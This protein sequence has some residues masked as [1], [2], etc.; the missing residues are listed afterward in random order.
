LPAAKVSAEKCVH[1]LGQTDARTTTKGEGGDGSPRTRRRGE[2]MLAELI[3]ATAM[4]AVG[5]D[6]GR[7]L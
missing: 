7:L 2:E 1:K 6:F 5:K 4:H 3:D